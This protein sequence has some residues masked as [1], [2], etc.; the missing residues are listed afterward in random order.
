MTAA[1]QSLVSYG[2][3]DQ[4]HMPEIA[5]FHV[6]KVPLDVAR[7]FMRRHHYSGGLGNAAMPWGVYD[8]TTG[9]L[10]AIIAFQTPISELVRDSVF[11]K[12]V[13]GCQLVEPKE[14]NRDDCHIWG[15]HHHLGEHVTELHRIAAVPEAPKNTGSWLISKGLTALKQYKPKYW[16]VI[17]MADSTEGHNGTLYQA[18]NADYYGTAEKRIQYRDQ[19]GRLRPPRQCGENI[20]MAEA[21]SR[22]W[23]IERRGVKHRYV[24]WLPYRSMRSVDGLREFSNLELQPYPPEQV[25]LDA[26]RRNA[27]ERSE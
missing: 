1:Q 14:C 21:K 20:S 18:A 2:D 7:R 19:D 10:L 11:G 12:S 4:D 25:T 9:K 27:G 8:Q 17:S 3:V 24:F 26:D 6:E 22:G 5:D 16:A 15:D 13:C 23:T